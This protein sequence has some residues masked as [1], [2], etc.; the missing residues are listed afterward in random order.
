MGGSDQLIHLVGAQKRMKIKCFFG[1][2]SSIRD[3]CFG[4]QKTI[5]SVADEGNWKLWD[6]QSGQEIL[7]SKNVQ[8]HTI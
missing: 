5:L 3:V 2:E 7:F 1:H 6:I 8:K 4:P